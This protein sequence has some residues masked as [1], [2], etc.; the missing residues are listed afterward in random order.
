MS[1]NTSYKLIPNQII[2]SGAQGSI[3]LTVKNKK[4]YVTK[5]PVSKKEAEISKILSGAIGPKVYDIY[6]CKKYSDTKNITSN[7]EIIKEKG[8]FMVIEKLSGLDL[9]DYLQE[10]DIFIKDNDKLITLLMNKISKLH[11]K[12]FQHND[13]TTSNVFI[14]FD[15]INKVKDIKIIDFGHTKK[16][17]KSGMIDDYK[18]LLES[19]NTFGMHIMDKIEPL[20]FEIEDKIEKIE[21]LKKKSIKKETSPIKIKKNINKKQIKIKKN[22]KSKV[23]IKKKPFIKKKKYKI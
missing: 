6:E 2:G 22:I 15:K 1:C 19:I 12:G 7:G 21:K 23:K 5:N 4:K 20:V 9:N 11:K 8:R 18:T 16:I 17:T 10:E 3:Y 13:L 14:I